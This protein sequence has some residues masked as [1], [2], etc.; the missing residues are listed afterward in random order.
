MHNEI[1]ISLIIIQ[2]KTIKETLWFFKIIAQVECIQAQN[3]NR[4]NK[5]QP[6]TDN[7]YSKTNSNRT[8]L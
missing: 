4:K 3:K 2:L 7:E 5:K 1:K 6:E 8:C